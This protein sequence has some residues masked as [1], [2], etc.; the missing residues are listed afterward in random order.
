M[1]Y[2]ILK[3]FVGLWV[4]L[5]RGI[6]L[7]QVRGRSR[8]CAPRFPRLFP[9]MGDAARFFFTTVSLLRVVACVRCCPREK[10]AVTN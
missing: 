2:I 8:V 1:E 7:L 9:K 10:V 6:S 3:M 5:T 4:E